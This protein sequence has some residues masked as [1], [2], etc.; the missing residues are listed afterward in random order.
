MMKVCESGPKRVFSFWANFA[1]IQSEVIRCRRTIALNEIL[2]RVAQNSLALML[3]RDSEKQAKALE[4]LISST[5][6]RMKWAFLT[7]ANFN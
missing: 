2:N 7:W 4:K 5:I 1:R 3:S 6:S